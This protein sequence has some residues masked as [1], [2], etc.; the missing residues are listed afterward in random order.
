[1][2]MMGHDLFSQLLC[3]VGLSIATVKYYRFGTQN[4]AHAVIVMLILS[5]VR[6]TTV[7]TINENK[8]V[9][10]IYF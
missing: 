6:P 2:G 5:C 3:E 8:E 10:N 7:P 1:M 9:I 4:W